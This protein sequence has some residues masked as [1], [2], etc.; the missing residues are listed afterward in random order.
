MAALERSLE[1][2]RGEIIESI[3]RGEGSRGRR[4]AVNYVDYALAAVRDIEYLREVRDVMAHL[5]DYGYGL[6]RK[7][8]ESR[9]PVSVVPG[10]KPRS[11]QITDADR[12]LTLDLDEVENVL[13]QVADWLITAMTYWEPSN[14]AT[15][16]RVHP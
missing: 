3:G 14:S 5:E 2:Y 16:K 1:R 4:E 10:V 15:P 12:D 7:Q 8:K 9:A 6:G 11:L 13:D